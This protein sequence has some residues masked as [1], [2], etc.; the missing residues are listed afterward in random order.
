[1]QGRFA[2]MSD[3]V[4]L[5]D[6]WV[7]F[8]GIYPYFNRK[9]YRFRRS[10]VASMRWEVESMILKNLLETSWNR[11]KCAL[12][13]PDINLVDKSSFFATG[14]CWCASSR[15]PCTVKVLYGAQLPMRIWFSF[16]RF[17]AQAVAPFCFFVVGMAT[18]LKSR[19]KPCP[20]AT[21]SVIT[22]WVVCNFFWNISDSSQSWRSLLGRLVWATQ[23][24][25]NQLHT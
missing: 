19:V 7:I 11:Y 24:L 8:L 4:T 17:V 12:S 1:M 16:T 9:S 5:L 13:V 21:S 18:F 10:L 3:Q 6:L 14:R 25:Y 22:S 2:Q 15:A 23:G 20:D